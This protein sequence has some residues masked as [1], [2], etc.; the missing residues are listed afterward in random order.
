[1]EFAKEV[2]I[3]EWHQ[4]ERQTLTIVH[5]FKSNLSH[6]LMEESSEM[7]NGNIPATRFDAFFYSWKEHLSS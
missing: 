2:H 5:G 6:S 7:S 3:A 1:M 4:Q